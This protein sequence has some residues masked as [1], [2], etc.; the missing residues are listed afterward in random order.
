DSNI[1]FY[2]QSDYL[3]SVGVNYKF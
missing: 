2:E 3:L 1:K